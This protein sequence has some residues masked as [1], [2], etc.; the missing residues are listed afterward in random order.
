MKTVEFNGTPRETAGKKKELKR[1]RKESKVPAV[2]YGSDNN[3][4]FAVDEVEFNK[5]LASPD[6]HLINLT[7]GDH[8]TR[9]IVQDVQF[10]PVSDRPIHVDFLEALPGKEAN[11]SIPVKLT[12]TSAGVLAGGQL[13]LKMRKVTVKGVPAEMPDTIDIDIT[14][15][16]IGKAIKVSDLKGYNF[17]DPANSVI[18]RVKTARNISAT[19]ATGLEEE[20]AEGGEAAEG[21]EAAAEETP[22]A[23][24]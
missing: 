1:L 9:A 8:K 16:G 11:L 20:G 14:P 4:N 18:V 22:Q 17:L 10:D 12:G 13:V 3:I 15:L 6:L 5:L 23:E 2:L 24:A 19:T 21:A 7:V